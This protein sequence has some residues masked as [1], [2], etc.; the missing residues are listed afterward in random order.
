MAGE[1]ITVEQARR[2]LGDKAFF[3]FCRWLREK[4]FANLEKVEEGKYK[5]EVFATYDQ[6]SRF[7]AEQVGAFRGSPTTSNLYGQTR[8][9]LSRSKRKRK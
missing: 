2:D 7:V 5:H 4:G 8:E 9:F 6:L 3:A 1:Y